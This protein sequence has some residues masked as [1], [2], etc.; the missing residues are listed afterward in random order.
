MRKGVN[1]IIT[2]KRNTNDLY[3]PIKKNGDK[4]C[5]LMSENSKK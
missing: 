1:K 2:S 3:I 4:R 5:N